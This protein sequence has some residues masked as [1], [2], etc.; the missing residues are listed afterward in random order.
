M[1][2]ATPPST[3]AEGEK[4]VMMASVNSVPQMTNSATWLD[5]ACVGE[6]PE[7]A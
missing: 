5:R 1:M 4:V 7:I 3:S 2:A 6:N